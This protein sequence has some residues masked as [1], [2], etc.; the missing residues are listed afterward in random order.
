MIDQDGYADRASSRKIFLIFASAYILSYAFRSINAVIAPSLII[1]LQ[2]SAS[3]LGLLASAYFLTFA[4]M[5]LPVGMLLDRFGPRRV[6]ALLMLFAVL[7]SGLFA[8]ADSF[9]TLWLA[10]ALIGIG[11]SACLMAAVKAYASYFRPHLQASMSSWMLMTGSM[12][13][14]MVTAPVDAALPIIGWR[15]VFAVMSVMCLLAAANLWWR[16]PRLSK[17]QRVSTW[18]ELMAGYK[19]VFGHRHFWR[20]APLA[21]FQQGG[22][23]AFHGLW[24]GPWLTK[25]H[26]LS[27]GQ[28]A[29]ALFWFSAV[30]MTGYFALGFVTKAIAKRGKDEDVVMLWGVAM[31]LLL[32]GV[33]SMTAGGLGLAGWLSYAVVLSSAILT[34]STVNKPFGKALAGRAST[35]LNLLIFTGAFGLQWGMGVAIDAFRAMGMSEPTAMQYSLRVLVVSQIAAWAWYARPGRATSHLSPA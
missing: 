28:T 26:G 17:P 29:Q 5:Q 31:A 32:A 10:R 12:G 8:V 13:A 6:E 3:D 33:Q 19:Q 27:T 15:G 14:L 25:V 18:P 20:I 16:M 34:Y 21:I 9:L 11:V 1:D 22:F 2:L 30:L 24:M 7:G 23:M 35:A 4:L